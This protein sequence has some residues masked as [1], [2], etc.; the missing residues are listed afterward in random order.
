MPLSLSTSSL[1]NTRPINVT[2]PSTCFS[3]VTQTLHF[4]PASRY[5]SPRSHLLEYYDD[6]TWMSSVSFSTIFST[7]SGSEK[8]ILI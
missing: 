5:L 4:F 7:F 1:S 3:H 8:I 6:G 2:T